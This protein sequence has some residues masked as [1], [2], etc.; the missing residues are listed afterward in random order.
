MK[1]NKK[2]KERY[3]VINFYKNRGISIDPSK[4][5]FIEENALSMP[6]MKKKNSR[7]NAFQRGQKKLKE[8]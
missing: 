8:G 4:I 3:A 7:L 6:F 5:T 2:E 1:I